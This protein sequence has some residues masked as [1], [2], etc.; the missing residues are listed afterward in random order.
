LSIF[1]I[2]QMVCFKYILK[3]YCFLEYSIEKEGFRT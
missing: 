1:F 2:F 3:Y